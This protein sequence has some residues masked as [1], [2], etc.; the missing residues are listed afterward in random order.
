MFMNKNSRIHLLDSKNG[1]STLITTKPRLNGARMLE[2]S[3]ECR[4]G[5][6]TSDYLFD[7][8]PGIHTTIVTSS[9]ASNSP[10]VMVAEWEAAMTKFTALTPHLHYS[11]SSWRRI[12]HSAK[13]DGEP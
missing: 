10:K 12:S 5:R 11:T 2:G 9:E 6:S 13:L 8:M 7:G 4:K 3:H 1:R